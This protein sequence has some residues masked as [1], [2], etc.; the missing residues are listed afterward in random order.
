MIQ[1]TDVV[2]SL[3]SKYSNAPTPVKASL[4][5]VV[6]NILQNGI[7]LISTP[8]FT[9]ILTTEQY[10][11]YSVYQ[12]WYN[13]I[14]IFATLNL[15]CGVFNNGLTKFPERKSELIS[16]MQ[17][18]STS[19]TISLFLVYCVS[20]G[21]WNRV[22]QLD[23]IYVVL[24][25]VQLLF[26]PAYQFWSVAQRYEYRYKTLVAVTILIAITSPII[27]VITVLNV[28]YKAEARVFSYVLV[29]IAVGLILY[30]RNARQGKRWFAKD[31]WIYALKFN[32]PLLP[33]YLSQIVLQQS[34]RIMINNMVGTGEA[35]IYSVAY[36]LSTLMIIVT[37]AINNAFVPYSYQCLQKDRHEDLRKNA[38]ILLVLVAVCCMITV[39]VGPELI[40]LLAAKEYR[41]AKWIIP[42]VSASVFFMFLYNLFGNVEF[43]Y[44]KTNFTMIASCIAAGLNIL[45]N[46][47]FIKRFGYVA[48]G[49]T[50]MACYAIY[51]FAHGVLCERISRIE[52]KAGYIYDTRRILLLSVIFSLMILLCNVLYVYNILRY[53]ILFASCI[54]CVIFRNSLKYVI[55]RVLNMKKSSN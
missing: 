53:L 25:F 52:A 11:V 28:Q 5:F 7:S 1:I 49:Y 3:K 33:H 9:R 6:C 27:G 10:G 31:F 15:Y 34:D 2:T 24:I 32:I 36:T 16:S 43:Y 37:N 42:P 18:L 4:W 26:V 19:I 22:F 8:I 35:A 41:E 38:N 54:C 12:S 51:A 20:C 44:E 47:I 21:F 45:L 39:F 29:Q 17:G 48:A 40:A 30:I 55:C 50:T 14:A 46:F 13:I 23:T